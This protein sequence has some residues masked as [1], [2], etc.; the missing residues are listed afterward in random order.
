VVPGFEHRISHLPDRCSTIWTITPSVS[1]FFETGSCYVAQAG[2]MILLPR[3]LN[4]GITG[5]YL[6]HRSYKKFLNKLSECQEP[7]KINRKIFF[8]FIDGETEA[9]SRRRLTCLRTGTFRWCNQLLTSKDISYSVFWLLWHF[10]RDYFLWPLVLALAFWQPT[11]GL[12]IMPSWL[13]ACCWP[14]R[15]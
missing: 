8:C 1:F 6:T 15:F 7:Y 3:F 4:D 11:G 9:Q 13:L 12:S 14:S 5:V 2:L 10:V